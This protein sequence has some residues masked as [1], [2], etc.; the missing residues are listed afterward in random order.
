M[1]WQRILIDRLLAAANDEGGW[2]YRA[3]SPTAAEPTAIACLALRAHEVAPDRWDRGPASLATLQ[4][5]DGGVTVATNLASPCWPTGLAALA[6][7]LASAGSTHTHKNHADRAVEWLLKTAGRR[8][9]PRP[10]LFGHDPT[11][12]GW[13]W[14]D[15][16][17]SWVEPTGYATLALR[18]AGQAGH[19]RTREAV[20]LLWNRAFSDG[21]WNY[22]NTRILSN[23]L[24]P[25]PGTTGVALAALAGE[26]EKPRASSSIDYLVKEL[27]H[28][29]SPI[30]LAWGLIGLASWDARPAEAD[31]WLAQSARA[32][33][34]QAPGPLE[35]ALLLLAAVTTAPL[36]PG[37]EGGTHERRG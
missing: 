5:P 18:A 26:P 24:C 23:T 4:R 27:E 7:M 30:S 31:D 21:G 10:D 6:W 9:R 36:S 17:H 11:L 33:T 8:M 28:V 29:R 32:P 35:D 34:V 12:Q 25:F 15:G 13:P 20:R 16:T 37:A 2:G 19:A 3:Q 1:A 22:G 14:V